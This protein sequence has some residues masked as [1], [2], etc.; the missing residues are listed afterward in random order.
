LR[1]PWFRRHRDRWPA[2]AS[3][4][5]GLVWSARMI[6]GDRETLIAEAMLGEPPQAC[7]R[8]EWWRGA[9]FYEVYVRSF[10]DSSGNGIGDLCGVIEKLDYL[11]DLGV[12]GIWLSPFYQ[13]PQKD[14]GYDITDFRNVDPRHGSLDDF[15]RLLEEA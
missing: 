15:V 13:S 2:D 4:P 5:W 11:A 9:V 1:G 12:D 14:F 8:L 10:R 7:T 6:G 3:C